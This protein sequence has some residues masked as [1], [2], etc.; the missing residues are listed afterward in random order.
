MINYQSRMCPITLTVLSIALTVASTIIQQQ[1]QAKMAKAQ[2]RAAKLKHEFN[3]QQALA[4]ANEEREKASQEIET[5]RLKQAQLAG[6]AKNR[7][8]PDRS[9]AALR[10]EAA[11]VG[12]RAVTTAKTNFEH[13][14]R[15]AQAQISA[16]HLQ[17]GTTLMNIKKPDWVGAG[18]K[19]GAA[20]INAGFDGYNQYSD[21]KDKGR[22]TPL[23]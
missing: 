4:R 2:A 10:R 14:S 23:P 22:S 11:R 13:Q 6:V 8:L 1:Q 7:A 12:D 3:K 15:L 5:S 16:S 20:A 9:I 18:L 21:N 19:I 17:M